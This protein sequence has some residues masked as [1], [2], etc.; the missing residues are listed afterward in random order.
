M[1]EVIF[2]KDSPSDEIVKVIAM[3]ENKPAK[4][5]FLNDVE[6]ELVEKAISQAGF[7]AKAG[8]YVNVYGGVY[9]IVLYGWVKIMMI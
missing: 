1:L 8:E 5:E 6:A 2:T 9:Q 7:E 4:V 3:F